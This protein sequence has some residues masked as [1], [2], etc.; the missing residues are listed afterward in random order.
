MGTPHAGGLALQRQGGAHTLN[1]IPPQGSSAP[2]R[3]NTPT[4]NETAE[5]KRQFFSEMV[6]LCHQ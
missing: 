6:E 3:P 5:A 2:L 1:A 4:V